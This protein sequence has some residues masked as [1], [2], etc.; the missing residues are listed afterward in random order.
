MDATTVEQ[1]ATGWEDTAPSDDTLTVAGW[2]AMADRAAGW[3]HAAGGRVRREP[4]PDPRRRGIAVPVPQP[5]VT[6]VG[7]LDLEQAAARSA[8]SSPTG[9]P[10]VLMSPHPTPDLRPAG[11]DL[12]GHPPYLVRPRGR[13][14]AA[15]L[16]QPGS[17]STEVR[18]AADLAAWD[19]VLAAGF[20]TPRLACAA[21]TARWPDALLAGPRATA[22]RWRRRC[23]TPGTG[24]SNVEAIATLPEPPRPRVSAP[25]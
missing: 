4:G 13:G 2:R 22:C 12:M 17:P 21:R 18:D 10:F 15:D 24:W 11:L 14:G 5:R 19:Q 9:R 7:P 20:P 8:G 3:A 16:P 25:P 23:P 1:P 6:R